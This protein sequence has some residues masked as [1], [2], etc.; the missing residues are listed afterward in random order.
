MTSSI[1]DECTVF[2]R[3]LLFFLENLGM[4]S[5]NHKNALIL[6]ILKSMLRIHRLDLLSCLDP[7]I[8]AAKVIKLL[9]CQK[10]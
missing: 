9:A 5:N 3:F 6:L 7:L 4:Q 8:F 10:S 1:S 2:V